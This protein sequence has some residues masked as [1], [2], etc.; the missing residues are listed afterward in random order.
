MKGVWGRVAIVAAVLVAVNLL[1]RLVVRLAGPDDSTQFV[2]GLWSIGAMMVVLAVTVF[3]WARRYPVPRVLTFAGAAIGS[4]SLLVMLIGPLVS[5]GSPFE[6]GFNAFLFQVLVCM[7][8]LSVAGAIGLFT[9]MALGLDP[10]SQAWKRQA[11]RVKTKP[12]R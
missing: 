7:L 12:R 2:I 5:G 4:S 1:A 9:A 8:V 3:L 10:K 6:N 11:E